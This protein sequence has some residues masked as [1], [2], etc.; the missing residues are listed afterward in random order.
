MKKRITSLF[1]FFVLSAFLLSAC[2]GAV[3]ATRWPG[4][5]VKDDKVYFSYQSEVRALRLSDGNLI[6]SYPATAE[7]GRSFYAAPDVADN[8]LIVGDYL[9]TLHSIDA[10]NG[11][12]K[13]KF[14]LD[15]SRFI[16]SSTI[17]KDTIIVPSAN[18]TIYAF[19]TQGGKK[20]EYTAKAANWAKPVSDD[21]NAY[22]ASM[23]HNLYALTLSKGEKVWQTDL[24]G[25]VTQ[26]LALAADGKIFVGT[27]N[28]EVLSVDSSNGKILWQFKTG[29]PIWAVPVVHEGVIYFGDVSGTIYGVDAGTG[30][31]KWRQADIGGG[32]V[33]AAGVM[34]NGLIFTT[35]V[36]KLIAVDFNGQNLWQKDINGKLYSSP[37][38]AGD[39]VIVGIND[40][41]A[42][43]KALDFK[44]VELWSYALPK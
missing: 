28:S 12:Q 30:V 31:Q 7:T 40:G 15:K 10:T 33:S 41:D 3:G 16:G 8:Q 21:Q 9:D 4:I 39:R 5:T 20:W 14:T 27:L 11:N 6:W 36:T 42:V 26:G 25:A 43:L 38:V 13:W 29:A 24:G 1:A 22:V 18:H 35:E 23:D 44:G 34:P 19:D 17:A 37:V 2:T 32:V